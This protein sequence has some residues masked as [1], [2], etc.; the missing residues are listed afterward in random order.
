MFY[1]MKVL[2]AKTSLRYE[3]IVI[4]M[5]VKCHRRL[6]ELAGSHTSHSDCFICASNKKK[7]RTLSATLFF[8]LWRKTQHFVYVKKNKNP[9]E[10][11]KDS[12]G[13]LF[14][15]FDYPPV[16]HRPQGSALTRRDLLLPWIRHE[17]CCKVTPVSGERMCSMRESSHH[18]RL[19][20]WMQLLIKC[21]VI[22]IFISF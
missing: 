13:L 16:I 20:F 1:V 4:W 21:L 5:L 11:F 7:K 2:M 18:E 9:A 8:S 19:A 17:W 15:S 12:T 14:G 3:S 6:N 22:Y 10:P